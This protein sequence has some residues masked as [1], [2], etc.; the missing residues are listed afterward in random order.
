MW[1][2]LLFLYLFSCPLLA[3]QE[4]ATLPSV[5]PLSSSYLLKLTAGLVFI[6]LLIFAL[7]WL[8]KKMQLTQNSHNGLINV[9]SA[10]SVGHKER[11]A[12][13]E[14]GEEQILVGLTPGRIEKLHT[15]KDKLQVD[16]NAGNRV[17]NFGEKFRHMMERKA[18]A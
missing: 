5:D 18:D 15:L 13:I 8:M 6:V 11:I 10:I 1:A 7:A 9:V 14:V 17:P 4:S 16:Q 12:L 3:E 2:R